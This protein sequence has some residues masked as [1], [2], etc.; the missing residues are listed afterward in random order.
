MQLQLSNLINKL[1]LYTLGLSILQKVQWLIA[2][3]ISSVTNLKQDLN[4]LLPWVTVFVRS[5]IKSKFAGDF[6]V[7]H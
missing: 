6:A 7:D 4:D 5:T 1:I 3:L 2:A